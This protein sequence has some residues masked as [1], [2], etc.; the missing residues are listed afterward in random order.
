MQRSAV[1]QWERQGGCLPSMN[2]LLAIAIA[3]GVS[4]EWLGTGRGQVKPE[5]D[6][7]TPAVVLEDFVQDELEVECLAALRN[8]PIQTRRQLVSLISL[9]ARNFSPAARPG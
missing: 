5:A 3:T 8:I 2:H 1:A 4:L 7:W 6:Q 9:V